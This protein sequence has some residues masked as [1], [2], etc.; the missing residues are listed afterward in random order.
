[1]LSMLFT[2]TVVDVLTI[3]TV[4]LLTLLHFFKDTKSSSSTTQLTVHNPLKMTL[5]ERLCFHN[6][7]NN[8]ELKLFPMG[9]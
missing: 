3:V 9:Q 5:Q 4:T 6:V 1:M 7:L 2:M 8:S